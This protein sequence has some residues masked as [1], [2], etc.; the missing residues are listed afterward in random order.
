MLSWYVSVAATVQTKADTYCIEICEK[1]VKICENVQNNN[2]YFKV[3]F[4]ELLAKSY[5]KLNDRENAQM[6]CDLGIQ[7]AKANQLLYLLVRLQ[8]LKALILRETLQVQSEGKNELVSRIFNLYNSTIELA[9]KLN[10]KK[11]TYIIEKDLTSFKAYCQLNR[12]T[13][14]K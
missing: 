2:M 1:A 4:Q 10:L 8:K 5:L 13:T 12:I 7:D 14:D 9:R 11:D 3:L 6:Y